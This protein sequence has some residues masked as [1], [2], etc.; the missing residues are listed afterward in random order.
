MRSPDAPADL[1]LLNTSNYS[2]VPIFPYAFVQVSEV[3][4]R[5]GLRV[6]THDLLGTPPS[7]LRSELARLIE[8]HR[9]R[10]LGIHLRQ[11]DSL[12]V[13]EYRGYLPRDVS[14]PPLYPVITTERVMAY[15]R[16]LS[17]AP[18]LLGGHGFTSSARGV[19]ARLRPDVGVVGEPDALFARFDDVLARRDLRGIPNLMFWDGAEAVTTERQFFPPAA[20][21]EYTDEIIEEV[22]KF[23]GT[24]FLAG[25]TFAVEVLRGCPYSCYFCVEPAVKGRGATMRDVDAVMADI[26]RLS[27]HGLSRIWLVCSE[28][29][30]FGA[31]LALQLAER[32][33][34]LKEKT[35]RDIRWYAFSL[36]VRLSEETWRTL[37]RAGFRGGFNTFMSLDNENLARG[38]IPHRAED[39]LRE[40]EIIETVARELGA[41]ADDLRSRGT[42]ALMFGNSFATT[43]T[44]HRSLRALHERGILETMRLPVVISATR[45]FETLDPDEEREQNVRWSFPAEGAPTTALDFTEPTYEYPKA[46]LDHFG[47]RTS[48]DLFFTWLET[49]IMSKL[50][51]REKDWALFLAN[52][53]TPARLAEWLLERRRVG[54]DAPPPASALRGLKPS[55]RATLE[56]LLA[57]P[58]PDGART[59]FMAPPH[60]RREMSDVARATL[61]SLFDQLPSVPT[62][63]LGA[64]GLTSSLDA[65]IYPLLEALYARYD[66]NEEAFAAVARALGAGEASLEALFVRFFFH[67]RNIV[68]D[69]RYRQ[70]LFG[71]ARRALPVVNP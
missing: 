32:I 60:L 59:L 52:A 34:K 37:A 29:N 64:L 43:E 12:L 30:I 39:A 53:T 56:A 51:E 54:G 68:I 44:V 7:D 18:I 6:V 27:A 66:S 38:R 40:Y 24:R 70:P 17:Q 23:Y 46:L 15:L 62:A 1:L 36:P 26:E 45:I 31:D 50:H 41:A 49:T 4:R 69:P 10:A 61:L 11:T 3:A 67:L 9:P 71:G 2:R 8:R 21:A 63:V 13:E 57:D 42:M 20:D 16:D 28:L 48:L 25:Q 5:H 35:G 65:P 55:A 19:F 22:K 14:A 47:D 58:T 33:V